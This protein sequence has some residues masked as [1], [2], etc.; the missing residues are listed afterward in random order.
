MMDSPSSLQLL[1]PGTC[2]Y[3]SIHTCPSIARLA[4]GGVSG[5]RDSTG[6]QQHRPKNQI[7]HRKS[8]LV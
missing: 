7:E 5:R 3:L 1:F 6:V 2:V 8:R 4:E